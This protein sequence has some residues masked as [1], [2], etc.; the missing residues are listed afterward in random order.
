MNRGRA[1]YNEHDSYAAQWLRNL[2][3]AGHIAPGDVDERDI[4]DVRPGDLAGYTQCHFFAGVGVWSYALRRAGWPDDRRVWT[5]SCPCQPFSTAGQGLGFDDQRHLWPAFF[6]LLSQCRPPVVFGEQV[7][8]KDGLTWLD[9]V[10]ADL[11]GA[12][13]AVGAADLCAAGVGA[14]HIRQRLYFVADS[15]STGLEVVGVE[16]ARGERP[17]VERGSATG[18]LA[19]PDG[20]H[21]SAERQQRGGEQ[22]LVTQDRGPDGAQ[23]G[24]TNGY[25][26]AADWLACRDG[27]WRPVESLIQSVAHEPPLAMGRLRPDTL[28]SLE[29]EVTRHAHSCNADPTT[30]LHPVWLKAC[31]QT[32][33]LRATGRS[34]GLHEPPVLLAFLRELADQR[35][36]LAQGL[37]RSGAETNEACLRVLR[38]N[39]VSPR[40][41]RRRGLDEQQTAQ[42]ADL[43]RVLSSVLARV[44]QTLWP[45]AFSPDASACFPL[46]HGARSRVGRLRAYGNAIVAEVATT[47]IEAYLA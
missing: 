23:P 22:R 5:G 47:F 46:A 30:A 41:P 29:T 4:L 42:L 33:R 32:L 43:V 20:R 17:A 35:W 31:S 25:W 37:P 3:A 13:Y 26:R 44:A 6:H 7:A 18:V 1:Y 24:P 16:P 34:E 36:P 14:P 38:G 11:E 45:E 15:S 21:S 9:L 8:S 28:A 19:D 40:A 10:R 39:P 2:I 12:E 27:R